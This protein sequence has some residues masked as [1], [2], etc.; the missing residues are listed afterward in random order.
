MVSLNCPNCRSK[1]IIK[2]GKRYN[3]SGE[4]QLFICKKCEKTFVTP[5]GFERMRHKPQDIVRA[6]SLRNDGFSLWRTKDHIWQ[7]DG[8]KVTKRT[9]SKWTNKYSIFLKSDTFASS[10]KAKRKTAF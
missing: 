7:H 4:K 8:V 6:V 1:K 5:D 10:A 3:L 2:R 9:I